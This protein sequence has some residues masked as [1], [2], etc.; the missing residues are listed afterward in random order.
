MTLSPETKEYGLPEP[1][2]LDIGSDFRVNLYRKAVGNA[3]KELNGATG[4]EIKNDTYDTKNDTKNDT[5]MEKHKRDVLQIVR[6]NPF[7]TQQEI[8]GNTLQLGENFFCSVKM[9][10]PAAV[11]RSRL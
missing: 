9:K 6:G 3:A 10:K 8:S 1:E 11:S 7:V 5:K 4:S 2:L